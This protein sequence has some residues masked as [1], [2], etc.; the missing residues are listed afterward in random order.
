MRL[1]R[2]EYEKLRRV[3]DRMWWFAAIHAN[4]LMLYRCARP[5]DSLPGRGLAGA[6]PVLD[7]G[8]GTGG[9]LARLRQQFPACEAIG[10]DADEAACAWAAQKSARPVCAGSVN[11]LPFADAA[12]ATIFSVD[13]LCHRD[14]DDVRALAQFHRCLA[15][16]G[17]LILNLP[18]YRWLMSR[19]DAAVYNAR[20]YTRKEVLALLRAA[21]FHPLFASYWNMLLFPL[22]VTMRKLLPGNAAARSDVELQPAIVEAAGRVATTIERALLRAGIRLPFG[23]S[24]LAVAAKPENAHA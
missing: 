6:R 22:M 20:R 3:E 9:L 2:A 21:G 18:A 11:E 17:I 10:L 12:F 15:A 16:G 8:C 1:E 23:G 4:L 24:V 13:V 5:D 7:A 19:H 14:V